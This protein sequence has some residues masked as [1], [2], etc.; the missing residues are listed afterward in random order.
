M[1]NSSSCS[2]WG[3]PHYQYLHINTPLFGGLDLIQAF[4]GQEYEEIMKIAQ[5]WPEEA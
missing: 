4:L 3:R 5:K 1:H 2:K